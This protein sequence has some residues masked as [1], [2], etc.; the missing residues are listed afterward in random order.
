[1]NNATV[2]FTDDEPDAEAF[3]KR[4]HWFGKPSVRGY[5][6]SAPGNRSQDAGNMS[7]HGVQDIPSKGDEV[8]TKHP[9]IAPLLKKIHDATQN[10]SVQ[11]DLIA[12][13]KMN[14]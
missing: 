8:I 10:P 4:R 11:T 3:G 6:I 1:M 9:E 5:R 12:R 7:S 14:D 13:L 2:F